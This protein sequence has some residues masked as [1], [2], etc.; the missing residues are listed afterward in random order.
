[1]VKGHGRGQQAVL[2]LLVKGRGGLGS[3]HHGF[4]LCFSKG[5]AGLGT[6]QLGTNSTDAAEKPSNR[7]QYPHQKSQRTG[8]EEH[9]HVGMAAAK[10]LRQHLTDKENDQSNYQRG[11]ADRR[12]PPEMCCQQ[13]C[14]GR[15]ANVHNVVADQ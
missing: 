2:V 6:K 15:A 11:R 4:Q 8:E 1:M 14:Q 10:T 9:H 13:G 7:L 3:L 5:R 12:R